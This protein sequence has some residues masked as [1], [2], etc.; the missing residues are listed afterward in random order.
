TAPM[1]QWSETLPPVER[2]RA[3]VAAA[4]AL[5]ATDEQRGVERLW[6][7]EAGEAL[8]DFV[9][10]ALQR[11]TGLPGVAA[12]GFTAVML[13]LLSGVA[14]R[15]R[16]GRHPRLAIWGPLEARLQ[17]ADLLVL[18]SLNEGTWPGESAVDPWLN[19][20]MRQEFGLPAPERKIG[21]SAHDFQQ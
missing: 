14:V 3:A 17:Q 15:P 1:A 9:H 4:E 13:E 16:F 19:R 8:S 20:P 5:A 2:L 7:D 10:D 18:G 6:R 11:F 21:L 12:E